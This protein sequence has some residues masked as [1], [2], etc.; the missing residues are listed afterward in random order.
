MIKWHPW[1]F[2]LLL[3]GLLVLSALVALPD[4]PHHWPLSILSLIL[5]LTGYGLLRPRLGLKFDRTASTIDVIGCVIFILGI[6]L[7]SYI[8]SILSVL[9]AVACPVVWT[10]AGKFRLG[11]L[12]N[13]VMIIFIGASI[14]L[15]SF[16]QGTLG[17]DWVAIAGS[18]SIVM[19][20]SIMIGS[21]V[22]STLDWGRE[23]AELLTELQA[24][25]TDLGE[26]Y[27]QLMA[28]DTPHQTTE[29]SPLSSRETEVLALVS[30]GCTN[31]EIGNRLFISPATVKTHMEHILTK[32][33]AT[34]RTQAVLIA[35]Q[36][37]LLPQP[38]KE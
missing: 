26:S 18:I 38:T 11:V 4:I 24:S 12:A 21:M 3:A 6:A 22:H 28:A 1:W 2:D 33:G 15:Y 30:E 7:G 8:D 17:E 13:I 16:N 23:R 29:Q 27:R 31:R 36:E 14:G 9:L 34:T 19:V 25:Q 35:H 32:L 20:F 10:A 37:G 5:I